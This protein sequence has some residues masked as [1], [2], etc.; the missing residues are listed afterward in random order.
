MFTPSY[1]T[2]NPATILPGIDLP[3]RAGDRVIANC[4]Q[5]YAY[6]LPEM[7]PDEQA[8]FNANV[9]CVYPQQE[10]FDASYRHYALGLRERDFEDDT[11]D[12]VQS[13]LRIV[14]NQTHTV[15]LALQSQFIPRMVMDE[16]G[17]P[18]EIEGGGE[19][20]HMGIAF[21][22]SDRPCERH[23]TAALEAE[24][25]AQ[26]PAPDGYAD[27]IQPLFVEPAPGKIGWGAFEITLRPQDR[28]VAH[29]AQ[30]YSEEISQYLTGSGFGHWNHDRRCIYPPE[31]ELAAASAYY[32]QQLRGKGL[33]GTAFATKE[34]S[35][36][37]Y[38]PLRAGTYE[39]SGLYY[40]CDQ[41]RVVGLDAM[42]RFG[43]MVMLDPLT[44]EF[45]STIDAT[46]GR[47]ERIDGALYPHQVLVMFEHDL[48]CDL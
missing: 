44:G 33:T 4:A 42:A 10:S 29:C 7:T 28:V 48:P 2:P 3:L 19:L 43:S 40:F 31:G 46:G 27:F 23:A 18:I 24:I 32:T 5:A 25:T 6:T 22:I 35:A 13:G 36:E 45:W 38:P 16:K 1:V 26:P 12:Y 9:T 39:W 8:D 11:G 41:K 17:D 15:M 21:S 30:F 34:D 14:C 20:A 37:Q 47:R